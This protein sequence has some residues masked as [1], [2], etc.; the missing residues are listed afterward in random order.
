[1]QAMEMITLYLMI[2]GTVGLMIVVSWL[3]PETRKLTTRISAD[4]RRKSE[5]ML[6]I[7]KPTFHI[8]WFALLGRFIQLM[9]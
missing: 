5:L 9:K 4:L 1:M 2:L 3:G 7:T 8:A 6:N